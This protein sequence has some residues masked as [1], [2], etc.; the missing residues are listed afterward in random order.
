MGYKFQVS[1]ASKNSF[2]GRISKDSPFKV[3]TS[4]KP[5]NIPVVGQKSQ[6]RTQCLQCFQLR[7]ISESLVFPK[8][9][10]VKQISFSVVG[11]KFQVRTQCLLFSPLKR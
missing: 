9:N 1:V 11:Y 3:S 4:Q 6:V 5:S 10:K 7:K 8:S 2:T